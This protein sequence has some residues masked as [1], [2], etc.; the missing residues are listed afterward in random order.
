M[1]AERWQQVQ[2]LFHLA[3]EQPAE[4]RETFVAEGAGDD[5]SLA[6]AVMALLS[7]DAAEIPL[8]DAGSAAAAHS[9][10]R[11]RDE[12]AI[13]SQR[14]G[15]YHVTDFLGEGGMGVVYRATREDLGST[16]ALK[17]LRD[18]WV[19]P[20]RR[21][22]FALEQRMLAQLRHP[23]IAQ[24]YDAGSLA[25]GTPWFVMEYVAGTTLTAY[26]DENQLGVR[27]RLQLF[28]AVC[29]AVQHAHAHA[30]IHRDLKPSNIL[31][32]ASGQP[33]L[34]DFGIAKQL[35][36]LEGAD[37]T[38][39]GLRL[40]TPAYAAPEQFQGEPVGVHSD[41]YSLGVI[42]YEL[43]AGQVPFDLSHRTPSDTIATVL[44]GEVERPSAPASRGGRQLA[45]K[46]EW[47]DLD[48][49]CLT[50]MHRE[51]ARRYRT[52]EA[53]SRDVEHFLRNEPLEA[54]ADTLGYRA[55]KFV[56][57]HRRE[58]VV[59]VAVLIAIVSLVTFYTVRLADARDAAIS[60][61][62]SSARIQAF[63]LN[64]FQGGDPEIGPADTLRVRDLIDRGV[65]EAD[66]LAAEPQ[67]RTE[68]LVTLAGI[69]QQLGDYNGADSLYQAVLT[70]R[71]LAREP[72]T[73]VTGNILVAQGRLR[74][75]QARYTEAESLIQQG[76]GMVASGQPGSHPDMLAA[77]DALSRAWLEMGKYAD[78]IALQH[79][80]LA[81]R[82][83]AATLERAGT[84]VQLASSY[85]YSGNYA[86][87]DSLN[88]IALGIYQRL[89]GPD[90]PLVADVLTN[91][92]ASQHDRG[93]YVAAEQYHRRALE[94][95]RKFYG[96]SH[97][98]TGS[99]LTMVGRAVLFQS[100]DSEAEALLLEALAVQERANG[101]VHPRVASALNELGNIA[102]RRDEPDRAAEYY[103]RVTDI[104]RQTNGP[105]HWLVGIAISNRAGV[106]MARENFREAE[107]GYRAAV[108]IFAKSQG[109]DHLNTAIAHIKL[110]RSLLRQ[111]LWQ[112]S[113]TESRMGY[114]IVIK[115]ADEAVSFIKAARTDL[116]AAYSALGDTASAERFRKELAP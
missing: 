71:S 12:E 52:V 14:F 80:V 44:A 67:V 116:V 88:L 73:G 46:R 13:R 17:I 74:I 61:A 3:L 78:A 35:D 6:A 99:T 90:H 77:D 56:R 86:A 91:L 55:G 108:A 49:L 111:E 32:T 70:E 82:G 83:P 53:L 21:E 110:G 22:R 11:E 20:S 5:P 63:M 62:A 42:L 92:G 34:L 16:A 58:T 59:G 19:S 47:R 98:A 64:L 10:F 7:A 97:V 105:D 115:R 76:R 72:E 31:V 84:L 60:E 68:L 45:T 4:Q 26:A 89:R 114:D 8:L 102:I 38:R 18:A 54:Q 93:E 36:Q 79:R 2:Q 103:D 107:A 27:Q 40:M 30:I 112:E 101:P 24:L 33:K 43:M 104:Y 66:A 69:R 51:P 81:N 50:A 37:Q 96:E 87:S 15:P 1:N 41:V 95:V 94:I 9:L 25:D 28:H 39:T 29:A 23:F 109:N 100:R 106:A 57:R 75:D 85:F 113:A 65:R 48:V